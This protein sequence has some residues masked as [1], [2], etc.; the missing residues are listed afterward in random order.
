MGHGPEHHFE[1][2]SVLGKGRSS[3]TGRLLCVATVS[4]EPRC[5]R[6]HPLLT[7]HCPE[8]LKGPQRVGPCR[9]IT[10]PFRPEARWTA[11]VEQIVAVRSAEAERLL[12]PTSRCSYPT[13][14]T[15]RTRKIVTT[16]EFSSQ[17]AAFVALESKRA[18]PYLASEPSSGVSPN[19]SRTTSSTRSSTS[20]G[21]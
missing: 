11:A 16:L 21:R 8:F 13:R 12:R 5:D 20:A 4:S 18:K 19:D 15:R 17:H 7:D 2:I 10:P 3:E 6:R 9:S 14:L 1:R